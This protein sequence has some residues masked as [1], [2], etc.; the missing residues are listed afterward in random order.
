M[1]LS[2]VL[3][4]VTKESTVSGCV[5]YIS[6]AERKDFYYFAIKKWYI[7]REKCLTWSF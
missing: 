6:K 4:I 3:F 7:R 5:P 2:S 1:R